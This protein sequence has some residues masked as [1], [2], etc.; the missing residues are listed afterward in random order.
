ML[1]ITT[2]PGSNGYK[3]YWDGTLKSETTGQ[4]TV[5]LDSTIESGFTLG[6]NSST[7]DLQGKI[8]VCQVYDRALTSGEVSQNY[9]AQ[10]DRFV[11]VPIP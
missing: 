8:A 6:Q 1:T 5:S 10:S 9:K 7:R 11:T 3:I 4:S 2:T